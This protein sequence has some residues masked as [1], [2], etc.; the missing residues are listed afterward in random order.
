MQNIF[1]EYR[2]WKD[3]ENQIIIAASI[4]SDKNQL[5]FLNFYNPNDFKDWKIVFAGPVKNINY[6]NEMKKILD[7]KKIDHDFIGYV[8]REELAREI[9]NSK[10][11]S[12]TTDPRPAQPFDPGPRIIFE[13]I[14]G[15]TPCILSDL[16]YIHEGS[17]DFCFRY[18]NNNLQSFNLM[19]GDI[20]SSNLEQISIDAYSYGEKNYTIEHGCKK[21]YT[22]IM[23][24]YSSTIE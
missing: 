3:R 16:V 6:K 18:K 12:L 7:Y 4:G 5:E 15:G 14:R 17:E 22:D 20:L 21:A 8:S 2:P 10:I 1:K 23:E 13:A 19:M 24:W 11:L 9:L